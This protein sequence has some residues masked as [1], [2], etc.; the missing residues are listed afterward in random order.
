M[1]LGDGKD[2]HARSIDPN[3]TNKNP[4]AGD[5]WGRNR[6]TRWGRQKMGPSWSGN[7]SLV[8]PGGEIPGSQPQAQF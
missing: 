5:I 1:G 3:R 7:L 4:P 6:L 2:V 8:F